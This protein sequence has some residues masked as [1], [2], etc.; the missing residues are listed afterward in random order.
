MT[1]NQPPPY[2][3]PPGG[4]PGPYGQ[5]PYGQNPYGQQGG[6]PG[7]PGPYGQPQPG[8]IPSYPGAPQQDMAAYGQQPVGMPPLAHWG[9]RVLASIID[10]VI[11]GVAEIILAIALGRLG[12]SIASLLALI[13][14]GYLE[15]TRGQTPGKMAVGTRVLREADGNVLGV[16]LAIGRR[17]LH[18]LDAL[19]CLL[20]FLWPLWDAKR[21]TFADKIVKSVV[22]KP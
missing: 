15:G 13:V 18:I 16:G 6:I 11:V 5:N 21:Q 17:L 1:E 12:P 19:A 20:G 8:G 3:G 22:I 14:F 4:Q 7:Q 2:G 9:W 10:G